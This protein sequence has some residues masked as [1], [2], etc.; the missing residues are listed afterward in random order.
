MIRPRGRQD[1]PFRDNARVVVESQG[2]GSGLAAPPTP[3]TVDGGPA[4]ARG[5]QRAER[6]GLLILLVPVVLVCLPFWPGHMNADTMNEISGVMTG[7]LTNYHAP[8]LLAPWHLVWG[9]GIGPG[10]VLGAQVSCFVFGV[11]LVMRIAFRPIAAA[12]AASVIALLPQDYGEL[13]LV[14]RDAWYTAFLMLSVGALAHGFATSPRPPR[15]RRVSLVV[16][17]AAAWL[18][19]AARQNAVTSV[20]VII[21]AAIAVLLVSRWPNAARRWRGRLAR[22]AIV[23]GAAIVV[24]LGFYGSQAGLSAAIGVRQVH[25]EQYI[26]DFD[27]AGMSVRENRDLFPHSLVAPEWLADLKQLFSI[28]DITPEI[29]APGAPLPLNMLDSAQVAVEKQSGDQ[30]RHREPVRMVRSALGRVPAPDLD[31]ASG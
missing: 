23:A 13:A 21:G 12:I 20:P 14:G 8:L 9:L 5:H 25:P 19:L 2:A 16:S 1:D 22:L 18:A 24:T 7:K 4:P 10:W 3:A 30:C 28:N 17:I 29:V 27:L 11:Y 31:H 15:V 6:I 26:Y